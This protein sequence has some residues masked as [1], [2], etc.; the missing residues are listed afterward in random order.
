MDGSYH[1]EKAERCRLMMAMA[2]VP[3]IKEQLR[4]WA[5]EFDDLAEAADRR[6][7]RWQ[8]LKGWRD[9]DQ[10]VIAPSSPPTVARIVTV[11]IQ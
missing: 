10:V 9:R 8:R 4:L 2:V 6:H 5:H 11:A 1:R 7:E 3:D